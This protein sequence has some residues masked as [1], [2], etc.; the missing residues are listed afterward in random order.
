MASQVVGQNCLE[1][2]WGRIERLYKELPDEFRYYWGPLK[3]NYAD[4]FK[5]VSVFFAFWFV[6]FAGLFMTAAYIYRPY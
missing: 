3:D 6:Q 2:Y 4:Y 5:D 1:N